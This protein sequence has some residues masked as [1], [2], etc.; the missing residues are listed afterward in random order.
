MKN[1]RIFYVKNC[2]ILVVKLSV[3]LNRRVFVMSR[4]GEYVKKKKQKKKTKQLRFKHIK[5]ALCSL[6]A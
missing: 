1:I 4:I 5:L 2:H 3:Y 6:Y